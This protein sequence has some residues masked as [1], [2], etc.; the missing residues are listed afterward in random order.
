MLTWA[1]DQG[2]DAMPRGPK[3]KTSRP[4]WSITDLAVIVEAT[5]PTPGRAIYNKAA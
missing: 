4:M 3:A 1:S 2:I 5:M